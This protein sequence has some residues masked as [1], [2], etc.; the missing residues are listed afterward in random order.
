MT[1]TYYVYQVNATGANTV[2]VET[3]DYNEYYRVMTWAE[4]QG[5]NYETSQTTDY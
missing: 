2:L 4:N 1:T 5:I 3:T